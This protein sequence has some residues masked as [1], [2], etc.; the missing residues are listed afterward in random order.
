[1]NEVKR[2]GDGVRRYH[3]CPRLAAQPGRGSNLEAGDSMRGTPGTVV[4]MNRKIEAMNP[5]PV[6][7]DDVTGLLCDFPGD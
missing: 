6:S 1:V 3:S 4:V 5:E 7:C 2:N